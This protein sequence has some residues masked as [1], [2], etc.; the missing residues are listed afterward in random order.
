LLELRSEDYSTDVPTLLKTAT[1]IPEARR[2]S[3]ESYAIVAM[4]GCA[5]VYNS[6]D[7][8]LWISRVWAD[9]AQ[10]SVENASERL[11]DWPVKPR[12]GRT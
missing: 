5:S 6:A 1:G 11:T 2:M 10:D 4:C 3:L 8:T 7:L 12:N 9:G